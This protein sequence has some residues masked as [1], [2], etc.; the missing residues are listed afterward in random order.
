MQL[1]AFISQ[2]PF[3]RKRTQ[4]CNKKIAR[5]ILMALEGAYTRLMVPVP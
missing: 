2:D 1:A 5:A 3:W 4:N